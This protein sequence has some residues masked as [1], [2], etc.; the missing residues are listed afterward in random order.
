MLSAYSCGGGDEHV[1][2]W[3]SGRFLQYGVEKVESLRPS[4]GRRILPLA[5]IQRNDLIG[6]PVFGRYICYSVGLLGG[7][8]DAIPTC[9]ALFFSAGEGFF[10]FFFFN[11]TGETNVLPQSKLPFS[12]GPRLAGP[13][14]TEP[15]R[16]EPNWTEPDQY[17]QLSRCDNVFNSL[18]DIC[19]YA[20]YGSKRTTIHDTLGAG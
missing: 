12:S 6:L 19:C 2:I 17:P 7:A 18:E 16:T 14:R 1:H 10:F 9:L 8:G 3:Y 13:D 15:N 20:A 4:W 11:F 5:A